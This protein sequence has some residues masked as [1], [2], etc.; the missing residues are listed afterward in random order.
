MT[1]K[2]SVDPMTPNSF[3]D[4]LHTSQGMGSANPTTQPQSHYNM[5]NLQNMMQMQVLN[6]VMTNLSFIQTGDPMLDTIIATVAQTLIIGMVTLMV[7]QLGTFINLVHMDVPAENIVDMVHLAKL[8]SESFDV[9]CR[10]SD[11]E[12]FY[13]LDNWQENFEIESKKIEYGITEQ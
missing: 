3:N 11:I 10:A 4:A 6:K 9:D 1:T 12:Q 5:Y 13:E 7:T 8:V 2:I